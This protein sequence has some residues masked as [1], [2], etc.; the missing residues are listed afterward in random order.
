[1]T[2]TVVGVAGVVQ[3]GDPSLRQY[4]HDGHQCQVCHPVIP[5]P[6]GELHRRLQ[7]VHVRRSRDP[8]RHAR[9]ALVFYPY[10]PAPFCRSFRFFGAFLVKTFSSGRKNKVPCMVW[11]IRRIEFAVSLDVRS[12]ICARDF[13]AATTDSGMRD[14]SCD[15]CWRRTELMQKRNRAGSQDV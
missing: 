5:T 9:I 14:A 3:Y 2:G 4:V 1:V 10:P 8:T 7:N 11:Q 12:R 15:R 6:R 13:A